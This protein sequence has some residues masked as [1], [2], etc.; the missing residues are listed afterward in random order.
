[1]QLHAHAHTDT[2]THKHTHTAYL[3]HSDYSNIGWIYARPYTQSSQVALVVNAPPAHAGGIKDIGLTPGSGRFLRGGN[4]N[5]LQ[6]TC[7][8][9]PMDRGAWWATVYGVAKS[10]TRL[11]NQHTHTHM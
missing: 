3:G 9:D 5:P 11:S 7:L 2:Y 1:M 4:G 6:Y 10:Q 8:E